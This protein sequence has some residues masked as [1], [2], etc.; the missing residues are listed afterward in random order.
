MYVIFLGMILIYIVSCQGSKRYNYYF[1]YVHD[2]IHLLKLVQ[3]E[4]NKMKSSLKN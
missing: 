1:L 2:Y 4:Y 3:H